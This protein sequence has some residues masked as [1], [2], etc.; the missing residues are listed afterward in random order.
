MTHCCA[1]TA[2][3]ELEVVICV[4]HLYLM[5]NQGQIWKFQRLEYGLNSFDLNLV[6]KHHQE[7]LSECIYFEDKL[8]IP[9]SET[10]KW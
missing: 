6:G 5:E 8:G 10:A 1:M 3:L 9:T 7:S 2:D 4:C